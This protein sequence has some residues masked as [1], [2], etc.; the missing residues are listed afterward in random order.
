MKRTQ[1]S[2]DTTSAFRVR[3][4]RPGRRQKRKRYAN[5]TSANAREKYTKEHGKTKQKLILGARDQHQRHR[6]TRNDCGQ[7]NEVGGD[8][9][10]RRRRRHKP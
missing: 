1:S 6:Q 3:G 2:T 7:W 5:E 4:T 9:D 8:T 10:E